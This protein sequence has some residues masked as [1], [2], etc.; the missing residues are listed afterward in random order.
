MFPVFFGLILGLMCAG[1]QWALR[2]RAR[3]SDWAPTAA[4]SHKYRTYL[5]VKMCIR[6]RPDALRYNSIFRSPRSPVTTRLSITKFSNGGASVMRAKSPACPPG[7]SVSAKV[8]SW[9][10]SALTGCLLYTSRC[11]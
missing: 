8:L 1:N 6:D 5:G 3:S 11:V 2:F 10:M 9:R 7:R 4:A